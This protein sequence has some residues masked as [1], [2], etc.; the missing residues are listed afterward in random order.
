[1]TTYKVVCLNCK[2][3]DTV[4]I[5]D[6]NHIAF[7]YG[8]GV[9]TNITAARWRPD[10]KWGFECMCGNYDLLAKEEDP[11]ELVAAPEMRIT[12]I[13]NLLKDN[14]PKFGFEVA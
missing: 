13:I 2:Q 4:A 1:M 7:Q 14:K 11:K 12:E 5:D 6:R 8:K 9:N 3:S 10:L